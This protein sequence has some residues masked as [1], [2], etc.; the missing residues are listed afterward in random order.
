M[1]DMEI[2]WRTIEKDGI[3]PVGTE[4]LCKLQHESGSRSDYMLLSVS[5]VAG[6]RLFMLYDFIVPQRKIIKY[7]PIS[8]LDKED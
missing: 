8:E 2:N 1:D 4:C 6:N 7:I 5:S 3:P